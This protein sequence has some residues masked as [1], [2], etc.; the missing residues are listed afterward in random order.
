VIVFALLLRPLRQLD[1]ARPQRW[2]M[3]RHSTI[4]LLFIFGALI[5]LLF[6]FLTLIMPMPALAQSIPKTKTRV[7][8]AAATTVFGEPE[9]E[10]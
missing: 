3:T 9:Q 6:V 2:N 1:A 7:D 10:N 8:V 5:A 4:G